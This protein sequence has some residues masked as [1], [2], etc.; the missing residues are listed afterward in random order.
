M[1]TAQALTQIAVVAMVA[2]VGGLILTRFKQP[3]VLGYVL[4]GVILGP[5]GLAFVQDREGVA[6]LAELGVLLLLFLVGLELDLRDFI[7][8]WKLSVS[9]VFLQV[10]I[11]F[12]LILGPTLLLGGTLSLAIF[13]SF[14]GALSSTAVSVKMLES[15]GHMKTSVGH[16]TLAVLIAQ[17]LAFV[18]MILLVRAVG[19]ESF[20]GFMAV[21]IVLSIGFL[22]FLIHKL[23]K[24]ARYH[25]P[26]SSRIKSEGD[27]VP[28]AALSFCFALA[29][30]TGLLGLS[31]A[32]GAFI[33]GLIMGNSQHHKTLIAATHP[34]QS[35]LMMV[36]F[37]SVG[38][39]LDLS[40]IEKHLLLVVL[41]LVLLSLLKTILNIG[42]FHY[43]KLA[44]PQA[45]LGGAML[46]QLG[47]FTFL[48]VGV[49]QEVHLLDAEG[50]K[51]VI[52]L[53]ALSLAFSPLWLSLIRRVKTM[54]VSEGVT[55]IAFLEKVFSNEF[56]WCSRIKAFVQKQRSS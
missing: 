43:L 15:T 55:F 12:L 8:R 26:F 11:S 17:D 36:F 54:R 10:I 25:L 49:G 21:K 51:L 32:Y 46:A 53:T 24:K 47:E 39:L 14:V 3:A 50:A 27:M 9:A 48:L 35:I 37:L 42:I 16:V 56:E 41:L 33:A 52:A 29:A 40:F 38:L 45:F 30:A 20:S 1:H 13:L 7:K 2:L 31:A 34:I 19:G 6:I 4:A 28:L 44:W 23:S 22:W 18:P 5:S